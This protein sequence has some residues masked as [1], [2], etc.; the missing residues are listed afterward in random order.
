[1]KRWPLRK[2][3]YAL[4]EQTIRETFPIYRFSANRWDI[5]GELAPSEGFAPVG[6][7]FGPEGR[8]WIL[9]RDISIW[10]FRNRI[11]IWSPQGTE[12]VLLT[13]YRRI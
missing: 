7:D 10:G 2:A 12:T 11:R 6:A 13:N 5:V 9:E 8:L 3:L 4:P 1:M